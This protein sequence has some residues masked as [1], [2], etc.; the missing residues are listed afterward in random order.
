MTIRKLYGL[1]LKHG[2]FCRFGGDR[3]GGSTV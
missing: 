2:L 3:G 1:G